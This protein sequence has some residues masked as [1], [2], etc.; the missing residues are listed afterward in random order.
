MIKLLIVGGLLIGMVL[1]YFLIIA[2]I[3]LGCARLRMAC[4]PRAAPVRE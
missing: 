2:L 4:L 1:V 3:P